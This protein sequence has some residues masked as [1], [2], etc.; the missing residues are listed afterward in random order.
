MKHDE[1][2][3]DPVA[4]G[5]KD[6]KEL[7]IKLIKEPIVFAYKKCD[8]YLSQLNPYLQLHYQQKSVKKELL[9]EDDLIEQD[10]AFRLILISQCN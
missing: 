8:E 7:S 2:F 10:E 6:D 4:K 5:N 1:Y 9:L 3:I